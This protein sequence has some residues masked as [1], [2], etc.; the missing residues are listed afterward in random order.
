MC[1]CEGSVNILQTGHLK[2]L[3]GQC[4]Q[5]DWSPCH[6]K[7]LLGLETGPW[8]HRSDSGCGHD[9]TLNCSTMS[10]NTFMTATACVVTP[11]CLHHAHVQQCGPL[12]EADSMIE[13][14]AVRVMCRARSIDV[15]HHEWSSF[16]PTTLHARMCTITRTPTGAE[17]KQVSS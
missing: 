16:P 8:C 14:W 6:R 2:T 11:P 13:W 12:H 15:L 17:N 9:M 1:A 3:S 5:V 4:T 10:M 7:T